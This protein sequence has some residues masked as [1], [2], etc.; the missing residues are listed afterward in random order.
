[1]PIKKIIYIRPDGAKIQVSGRNGGGRWVVEYKVAKQNFRLLRNPKLPDCTT[2]EE[3]EKNLY[4]FAFKKGWE[5]EEH[6]I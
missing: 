1:M 6:E 3:C 4:R 5:R 2:R